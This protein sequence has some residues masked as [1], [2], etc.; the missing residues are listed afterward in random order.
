MD[1][2][3]TVRGEKPKKSNLKRNYLF[4][5]SIIVKKRGDLKE[6]SHYLETFFNISSGYDYHCIGW[7]KMEIFFLSI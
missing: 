4:L 3:H 5:K 7:M 1:E 6:I 2:I